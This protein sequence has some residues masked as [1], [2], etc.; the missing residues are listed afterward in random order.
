MAPSMFIYTYIWQYRTSFK[1]TV[2]GSSHGFKR[3]IYRKFNEIFILVS[4]FVCSAS[5]Q[6]WLYFFL[7]SLPF[8]YY[9][10]GSQSLCLS[11]SILPF[12]LVAKQEFVARDF[13]FY[14][15][16]E[17]WAYIY[18]CTGSLEFDIFD[19]C[20][21][22]TTSILQQSIL[23][24]VVV[25]GNLI[26][27]CSLDMWYIRSRFV[28]YRNNVVDLDMLL[29]NM[30]ISAPVMTTDYSSCTEHLFMSIAIVVVSCL[31]LFLSLSHSLYVLQF[32]TG[33][34]F[35]FISCDFHVCV[36]VYRCM[37]QLLTYTIYST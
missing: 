37:C 20:L 17:N 16:A 22:F 19:I 21:N 7:F 10:F 34:S 29:C 27:F 9:H 14:L 2:D 24:V 33:V 12:C 26:S 28:S 13:F 11:F 30:F 32:V 6:Q 18:L 36:C 1:E 23:F 15:L 3:K 35:F 4:I 31:I 25:V 5:N 8:F